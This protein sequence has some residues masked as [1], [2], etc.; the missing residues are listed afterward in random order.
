M[1]SQFRRAKKSFYVRIAA[2]TT[3][4]YASRSS[5]QE[6]FCAPVIAMTKSRCK[7]QNINDNALGV[8]SLIDHASRVTGSV[9]LH[10]GLDERFIWI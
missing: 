5:D 3:L 4:S 9:K 2:L 7:N 1:P 10:K 6:R 8:L